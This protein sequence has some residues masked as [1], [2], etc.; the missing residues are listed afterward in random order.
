[1]KISSNTSLATPRR[2]AS[3]AAVSAALMALLPQAASA[4]V[5][6]PDSPESSVASR[7]NLLYIIILIVG[8]VAVVGVVASV[9]RAT[10]SDG[11]GEVTESGGHT[12]LVGATVIAIAFALLGG[13]VLSDTSGAKPSSSGVGSQF[14]A[15]PYQ[16]PSLVIAHN[17]K[18]PKGPSMTVHV[19]G[20]RYL[21]RYDYPGF[22][23]TYSYHTLVVPVGVTVMLDVTSSDVEHSWWVPQLGG[24]IDAL[25]GYINKAWIKVDKAGE[26]KGSSTVISGTNYASMTTSVVAVPPAEFLLWAAG[27]RIEIDK[28]VAE[29]LKERNS[30]EEQA[31]ISGQKSE[32]SPAPGEG[33]VSQNTRRAA[34]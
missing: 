1:L 17:V 25:P 8:L 28:A 24:S 21:W 23:D 33:A 16:D 14:K 9:F 29:L 26:Y 13:W 3:A 34:K 10:R 20:Q 6:L 32:R 12:A 4:G 15:T 19:N 2:I 7:V 5:V 30:G 18:A 11:P 27:K 22:K 31:L